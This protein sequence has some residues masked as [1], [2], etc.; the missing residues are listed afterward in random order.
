MSER[1]SGTL[2]AQTLRTA[3]LPSLR[4]LLNECAAQLMEIMPFRSRVIGRARSSRNEKYGG[5]DK[6]LV[7]DEVLNGTILESEISLP[8]YLW[9]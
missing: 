7:S 4:L 8:K 1:T 2:K 6:L 9:S 5:L 3:L